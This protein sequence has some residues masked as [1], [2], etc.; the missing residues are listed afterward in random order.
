[1]LKF[2]II[3][4][5]NVTDYSMF[6]SRR[7]TT[8]TKNIRV[9]IPNKTVAFNCFRAVAALVRDA[10]CTMPKPRFLPFSKHGI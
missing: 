7:D 1:M 3:F 4:K 8:D 10:N 5:F 2:T 6:N 9:H